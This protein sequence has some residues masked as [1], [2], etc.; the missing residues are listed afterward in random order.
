MIL[1]AILLATEPAYTG[2]ALALLPWGGDDTLIEYQVA[3][4]LAA[5]VDAVEVVLGCDAERIISLVSRNDVEPIVDARW[6]S[7]EASAVRV[8][9]AAV[10][11]DTHAAVVVRVDEP[12]PAA[13]YRRLLDEH[14]RAGAR[15]S[16]P[17]FEGTPGQPVVAGH[18]VLAA[19]RNVTT[20]QELR[21]VLEASPLLVP[22]DSDVVLLRIDSEEDC[23]R[24]RRMFGLTDGLG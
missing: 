10:P 5:G 18:D 13:V 15:V 4:L 1:A 8:G 20:G 9:A 21:D 3:Q 16:R 24:A 11:R 23:A 7:R 17:T 12:R 6:Q 19:L 2:E 14:L 22:F